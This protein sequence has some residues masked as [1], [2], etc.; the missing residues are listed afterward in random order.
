MN[1]LERFKKD[2]KGQAVIG[3]LAVILII[4][5]LAGFFVFTVFIPKPF[6]AGAGGA[7]IS[8]GAGGAGISG[9]AGG[10][11]GLVCPAGTSMQNGVCVSTGGLQPQE[12]QSSTST[13]LTF[14]P[15]EKYLQGTASGQ[16]TIDYKQ[17]GSWKA[18]SNTGATLTLSP[19][20]KIE[21]LAMDDDGAGTD[22]YGVK[23][24]EHL[25]SPT[26]RTSEAE[27]IIVV[28]EGTLTNTVLNTDGVT[29]N[30][31]SAIEDINSG[32]TALFKI[33]S[34]ENSADS[35]F[36]NPSNDVP[37]KVRVCLD[38]NTSFFNKLEV[39]GIASSP[40]G[41]PAI[42]I[43]DQNKNMSSWCYTVNGLQVEDYAE[44]VWYVKATVNSGAQ[45][46]QSAISP[47]G[48]FQNI[49]YRIYDGTLYKNTE[50]GQIE[51]NIY[52]TVTNVD[53]G[54]PTQDGN[55]LYQ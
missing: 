49:R 37:E 50:T 44:V 34:R 5:F 20:A 14:A 38:G 23:V 18:Q 10:G 42:H 35:A 6:E 55:I 7:G 25:T 29:K 41:T 2:T 36:G 40:I 9:G 8:G 47:N 19:K 54:A 21:Y 51:A 31:S 43:T 15:I 26:C 48:L 45:H 30:S 24:A 27:Q 16:L 12:C 53:I 33:T 46:N 17:D 32:Q 28:R 11:T 1:N 13:S 3:T 52:N 4:V 22:Y 39:A